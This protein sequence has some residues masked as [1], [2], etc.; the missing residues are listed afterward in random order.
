MGSNIN[1]EK[2]INHWIDTSN[3]DFDTM[4][5]LYESKS[6]HWSLFL[7]HI[8]TEKLLK[9]LYVKRNQ[10]HAPFTHNLYRLAEKTN[11][12]MNHEIED[13]LDQI[14]VFNLNA[15]YDDYKREFYNL[16]TENYCKEWIGKIEII[17]ERIFK[18]L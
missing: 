12:D 15:R 14:T 17:R 13:W 5:K 3:E 7:G 2:V 4:I 18:M 1:L 9:A 10:E 6:Y 16:C 11:L 8:S